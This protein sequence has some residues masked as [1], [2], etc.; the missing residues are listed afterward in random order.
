[1]L[2]GAVACFSFVSP[3]TPVISPV[4]RVTALTVCE[5]NAFHLSPA[6]HAALGCLSLFFGAMACAFAAHLLA[7]GRGKR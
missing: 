4:A 6:A 1:M 2:T 3:V 5:A 7:G